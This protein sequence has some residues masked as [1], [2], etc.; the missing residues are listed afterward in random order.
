MIVIIGRAGA[1]KTVQGKLLAEQ[2]D[3]PWVS[4]GAIIRAKVTGEL[5]NQMI[6]GHMLDD[7]KVLDL[8]MDEL[9]RI[10]LDNQ[11]ILD[12]FPRTYFQ[13]DW[14]ISNIKNNTFKVDKVIHLIA[15]IDVAKDRLLKRA[16][17]DDHESA[18]KE[19]F[20]EYDETITNI[21]ASMQESGLDV[22]EIDAVK[23]VDEVNKLIIESLK[24]NGVN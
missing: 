8:L 23:P 3:C 1:G 19:R 15:P 12:G 16:R 24:Q 4:V 20:S 7:N 6:Q 5:F 2:L 13:N 21:V 22:I 18:I 11:C 9:K 14:F 10:G 17:Q